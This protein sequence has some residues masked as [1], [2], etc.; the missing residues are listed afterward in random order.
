M[1]ITNRKII[2]MACRPNSWL[3][4]STVTNW[5]PGAASSVRITSARR[6]PS[7]KNLKAVTM[8]MIPIFLWSTVVIHS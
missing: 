3:Y 6:P 2:V 1:G 8:Y 4:S 5:R 7:R